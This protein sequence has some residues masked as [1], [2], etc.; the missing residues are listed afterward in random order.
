M[1]YEKNPDEIGTLWKNE[2][3]AGKVYYKGEITG[4]GE[5]IAYPNTTKGGKELLRVLRSR[6]RDEQP[7][8]TGDITDVRR[9]IDGGEVPF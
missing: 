9:A 7:R 4:V 6:P 2:S 8:E 1:A 3:R 5:V